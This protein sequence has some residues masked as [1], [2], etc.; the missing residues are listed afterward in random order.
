M[1]HFTSVHDV[2]DLPKLLAAARDIKQSPLAFAEA[3]RGK[4]MGIIFLNPSLR[5]RISTQRA[6][7]NLGMHTVVMNIDGEGWKLEFEDGTVM[8]SDKAEHIK[9]AAGV[10]G[11]YFDIIGIR[12]FPKLANRQEDY[13]DQVLEQ[14]KKYTGI[15]VVSLESAIRHPLQSLADYLTIEE[16]KTVDRPKVVLTWVP[17]PRPLPQAVANSFLEWIGRADVELVVTHPEGYE[18]APEF[19]KNAQLEYNQQKALEGANFVYAKN[20][21][22]WSDY[23]RI[24]RT[25]LEWMVT[26]EKMALARNA[27]F[28]HC[29][30]VRR[31]VVV[32]DNVL[33]SPGSLVLQQAENRLYAAQAVLKTILEDIQ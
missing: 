25:D 29:L 2:A 13:S 18:L 31:N 23:G 14:F 3:G 8:D 16:T 6:A 19:A 17:H 28:M 30:P 22:S 11:R 9:D 15:P 10:M 1:K 33:D 4:S 21:S 20:W 24:L 27:R 26:G 5:T 12:S 7:Q 32:A